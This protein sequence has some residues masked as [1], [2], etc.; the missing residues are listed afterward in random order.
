MDA[1]RKKMM[2]WMPQIEIQNKQGHMQPSGCIWCG[3]IK[4][5]HVEVHSSAAASAVNLTLPLCFWIQP[6][7]KI[8]DHLLSFTL[9]ASDWISLVY[10]I[11]L[12]N[13][14]TCK[15]S[16]LISRSLNTDA[17]GWLVRPATHPK[18]QFHDP[19]MRL[20]NRPLMK[21]NR[22]RT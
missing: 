22:G 18:H 1:N 15:M 21:I 7:K 12:Y 2:I 16:N 17:L 11:L 4:G 10:V 9:G 3:N 8:M 6:P 20:N 13:G 19:W 5:R 14:A